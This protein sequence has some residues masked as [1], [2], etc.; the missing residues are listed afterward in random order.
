MVASLLIGCS[1]EQKEAMYM[2]RAGRY[3]EA[4]DFDKAQVEYMNVI[5]VN[6]KNPLALTRLGLIASDKG[7]LQ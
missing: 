4:K 7:D 5:R 2:K 3:F 1:P 6:S